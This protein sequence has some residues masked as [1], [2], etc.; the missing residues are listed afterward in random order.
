[1]QESDLKKNKFILSKNLFLVLIACPLFL[2]FSCKTENQKF[3]VIKKYNHPEDLWLFTLENHL[4]GV[5]KKTLELKLDVKFNFTVSSPLFINDKIYLGE[6][7]LGD[8][9]F[10]SNVICLDNNLKS[11]KEIPVL[12]NIWNLSQA[13]NFLIADT[14]CYYN[15]MNSGFSIIDLNKDKTIF[16]YNKLNEIICNSGKNWSYNNKLILGTFQQSFNKK[17]FSISVF[18]L[19]KKEFEILNSTIFS[20]EENSY[21]N[22]A[23]TNTVIYKNQL[24]VNYFYNN[25]IHVY[26]LDT[27]E[28][29]AKIDLT[30]DSRLP[31]IK[32][33]GIK[34]NIINE[35]SPDAENL[36]VMR[37]P[38]FINGKYHVLL[39]KE[40]QDGG[41]DL[42]AILII[43]PVSFE[44]EKIISVKK[45]LN[46]ANEIR[47]PVNKTDT[48]LIR[49]FNKIDEFETESGNLVSSV[50][51]LEKN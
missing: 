47:Y 21:L 41:I 20:S 29:I 6:M 19:E 39:R 5:D 37:L 3:N 1:M 16:T 33:K 15:D 28:C 38:Q 43:D 2:F 4:A 24:W 51:V 22:M 40:Y 32:N 10:A 25:L 34:N 13:G 50:T 8:G 49:S 27:K 14:W 48:I 12:P 11:Y 30:K 36:Y 46:M 35:V 31:E 45:D 18:D 17:P 44:L 7:S 23:Y 9:K 42:N 26:D